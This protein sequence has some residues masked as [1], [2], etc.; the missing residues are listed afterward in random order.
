MSEVGEH[1][2]YKLKKG[3]ALTK[4]DFKDPGRHPILF[5]HSFVVQL[6]ERGRTGKAIADIEVGIILWR[7]QWRGAEIKVSARSGSLF[8]PKQRRGT[9]LPRIHWVSMPTPGPV[10]SYRGNASLAV[11]DPTLHRVQQHLQELQQV[12]S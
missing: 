1:A 6:D 10:A 2:L 5:M 11:W 9:S 3:G 7:L 4:R 12:Y 8:I